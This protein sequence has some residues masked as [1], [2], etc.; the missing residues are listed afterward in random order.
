MIFLRRKGRSDKN[1]T[2]KQW[3]EYFFSPVFSTTH[4]LNSR[5][6]SLKGFT[7]KPRIYLLFKAASCMQGPPSGGRYKRIPCGVGFQNDRFSCLPGI[8]PAFFW[9]G[10]SP[11]YRM[12][13]NVE[14]ITDFV[15][16]KL[17]AISCQSMIIP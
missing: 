2:W 15:K 4:H 16:E 10:T 5:E 1:V 8:I 12:C 6:K 17:T 9:L 7:A 13:G 14:E 11:I 3:H